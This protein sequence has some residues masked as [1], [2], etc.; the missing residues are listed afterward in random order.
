MMSKWNQNKVNYCFIS[1]H[2]YSI[3]VQTVPDRRGYRMKTEEFQTN[4]TDT[5]TVVNYT[6]SN[7][8]LSQHVKANTYYQV[9]GEKISPFEPIL[10]TSRSKNPSAKTN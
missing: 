10:S 6:R 4:P 3:E 2:F 7:R 5:E 9:G 8:K 1:E